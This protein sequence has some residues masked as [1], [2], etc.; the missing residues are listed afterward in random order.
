MRPD[1]AGGRKQRSARHDGWAAPPEYWERIARC[2]HARLETFSIRWWNPDCFSRNGIIR[3]AIVEGYSYGDAIDSAGPLFV[4]SRSEEDSLNL[5]LNRSVDYTLMDEL[6][7]QY[8]VDNHAMEAQ[9]RLQ[10]GSTPLLTRQLHF[11]IRRT[12]PDAA[13]IVD[14]FNA[15]RQSPEGLRRFYVGGNIY[16]DR[17]AVPD[18]GRGRHATAAVHVMAGGPW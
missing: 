16:H 11:A 14:R 4:R 3:I 10:F 15:A 5:L 18:S 6:V 7:V 9:T 13:S 17:A 1:C 2:R 12:R 8:I